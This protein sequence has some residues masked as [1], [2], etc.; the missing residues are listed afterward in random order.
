[1]KRHEAS[2]CH[3]T[4]LRQVK[5][6][7]HAMNDGGCFPSAKSATSPLVGLVAKPINLWSVTDSKGGL[8][9][10]LWLG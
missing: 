2:K 5:G 4:V 10:I 9:T 7:G 6:K 8:G 1:M 3:A